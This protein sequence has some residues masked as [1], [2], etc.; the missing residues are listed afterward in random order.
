MRKILISTVLFSFISFL[1]AQ[2]D[3]CR[4]QIINESSLVVPFVN[5]SIKNT[6]L[7]TVSDANGNYKLIV[8]EYYAD[9]TIC[10]SCIGY[11]SKE[12][13]VVQLR[14]NSDVM[15]SKANVQ[16]S[17]VTIMPDSTL[18]SFLRKAYEKIPENYPAYPTQYEAFYREGIQNERKQYI[19]LVEA[20]TRAN[21]SS[22][23][24]AQS[25]T[26]QLVESRKYID[27]D[28]SQSFPI[29]FY[30]G[31]H[32]IHEM[33]CVK[34][35]NAFLKPHNDY[36]YT[37]EGLTAY[38]GEEVH[39]VSFA[40]K[41]GS[42]KTIMG[43]MFIHVPTLSYLRFDLRLTEQGLKNRFEGLFIPG[44]GLKSLNKTYVINYQLRDSVCML[45]S[46]FENEKIETKNGDIFY[47]PLEMVITNSK[48]ANIAAIPFNSQMQVTYVPDREATDYLES[49]WKDYNTLSKVE[50]VDTLVAK[51]LF[52]NRH[53]P[54]H[55]KGQLGNFLRKLEVS[56]K[57]AYQP[58]QLTSG[59]RHLTYGEAIYGQNLHDAG[60]TLTLDMLIAYK[61]SLR[62]NIGYIVE[63]GWSDTNL[64]EKHGPQIA[65]KL[66]LKTMGNNLFLEPQIAYVWHQFGRSV[67]IQQ[68]D[69]DFSFGGKTFKNKKVQALPG[70]KHHG[71]QAGGNLLYQ[72]SPMFYLDVNA[73]YYMPVATDEVLFMKEKSGFFLTR[74]TAHEPLD[75]TEGILRIDGVATQK[76]GATYDN[77]SMSIGLRMMF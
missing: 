14:N 19:R 31:P 38:N 32:F 9:V 52:N 15:L 60:T 7:G 61:L 22:Y 71:L 45:Q 67:G 64:Q 54:A 73:S 58:Y 21:K 75:E 76:S 50:V 24:N 77:W 17:E 12:I 34:E 62:I 66:P 42:N 70:I 10:F 48:T 56:Y 59:V 43:T 55:K 40:P 35:R 30:G 26:V 29:S 33:D 44:Y 65:Y 16:L 72:L 23:K 8:P 28:S 5:I 53:Q 6:C 51:Q 63:A 69:N 39:Q 18:R 47:S 3:I 46:I 4:G 20:I 25:G 49:D 37:Y 27:A 36:E 57:I 13:S 68:F 11:E 41:A 1:Y 2:D 74:K